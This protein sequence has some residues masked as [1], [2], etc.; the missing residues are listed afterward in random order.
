MAGWF[1]VFG[2]VK[3]A[4]KYEDLVVETSQDLGDVQVFIYGN[5]ANYTGMFNNEWYVEFSVVY[6]L[7]STGKRTEFPCYHWIGDGETIS[8]TSQASKHRLYTL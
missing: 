7:N 5:D 6:P 8:T 3:S 1:S 2:G 4:S